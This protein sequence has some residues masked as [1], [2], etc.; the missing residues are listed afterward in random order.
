MNSFDHGKWTSYAICNFHRL[1]DAVIETMPKLSLLLVEDVLQ[2]RILVDAALGDK[3]DI[4]FAP[5]QSAAL[6]LL[7]H[8]YDLILLDIGLPDG[9]GFD[10]CLKIRQSEPNAKV[11]VV[12]LTGRESREDLVAAYRLGAD[13]FLTK[14]FDPQVLLECALSKIKRFQDDSEGQIQYENV[15]LYPRSQRIVLDGKNE[16]KLTKIE[17]ELATLFLT[18]VEVVLSRHTIMNKVWGSGRSVSDRT[19]DVHLTNLRR[20]IPALGP[21]LE[22]VRGRGYRLRAAKKRT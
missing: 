4:A 22:A 13:D 9:D 12:F 14:P 8:K 15:N 18:N 21:S 11:P 7:K 3:F 16:V 20:K 5:T 6:S 17:F 2:F 19:I 1:A 10:L